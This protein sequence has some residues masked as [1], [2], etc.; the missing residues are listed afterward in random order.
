MNKIS[1]QGIIESIDGNEVTVRFLQTAA[2][3]SCKAASH[4]SASEKKEKVVTIKD[5]D[6]ALSYAKG[7]K[8]IVVMSAENGRLAVILAF[9]VPFFI[10]VVVLSFC[11][12]MTKNEAMAALVGILSLMPYYAMLHLFDNKIARQF[13]FDIEK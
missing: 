9:V 1:H 7:D 8:V 2:C 11:L 13:T 3:A 4:C 5:A 6:V 12:W 10:L